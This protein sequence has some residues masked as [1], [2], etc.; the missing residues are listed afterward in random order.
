MGITDRFAFL[1][2]CIA[3]KL[4]ID[5]PENAG[6]VS[7]NVTFSHLMKKV[8]EDDLYGEPAQDEMAY[9]LGTIYPMP[10]GLKDHVRWFLGDSAFIRQIAGERHMYE[11]LKAHAGHIGSGDIPFLFIDAL[12]CR[13]GC[14]CGTAT[15][16][17]ISCT[18]DALFN[19]LNIRENVKQDSGSSTVSRA[20]TPAERLDVLN[21]QFAELELSDY[22]RGYHDLS[23]GC[24]VKVPDINEL[25]H[26]FQSMGKDTHESR[27][28]NCTSCGYNTCI[29]MATAIFNGFNHRENCVHYLKSTVETE[30]QNL[31]YK[32]QHDELL[33]IFNRY[34]AMEF[35]L[36]AGNEWKC[37]S[38]MMIDIDGFKNINATYGHEFADEV[39][40]NAANRLKVA[41]LENRWIL[42]R[43]SG[44]R[45]LLLLDDMLT[46][47]HP[48]LRLIRSLFDDPIRIGSI[49]IRISVCIGVANDNGLMNAEENINSAEEAMLAAKS[50]G[51]NKVFFYSRE[52]MEK[53]AEEK[54]ICRKLL[55]AMDNDGF[56]MVYQPKV[57]VQSLAVTGFEA[58]NRMQ[59]EWLYPGQFIPVAEKKGWIWR[60]GRITTELVVRQLAEWRDEGHRLSPVSINYSGNQLSDGGYVDFLVELLKKYDIDPKYVEIEITESVFLDKTVQAK[61]LF[62]RFRDLGIRMLMDDFGTGYSSLGYLTYIPADVIKLDKSLVDNY[63]VEGKADFIDDVI[64]LVHDI[65]KELTVEGVEEN[66][67]YMRLKDFGAD[68]IQG[69]CFS[70]PLPADKA[71]RFVPEIKQ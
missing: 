43:Y 68:T 52:L 24:S 7:Y 11:Y 61:E 9:S 64:R 21:R 44:D 39:L 15:E 56:Y 67:Q 1:S 30:Q 69:Y 23:A 37:S 5:D 4:E 29:E 22:L 41:A 32:A 46:A 47:E 26:I 51:K 53:A 60:I 49:D 25:E 31:I 50:M 12:N 3:K 27:R 62:N 63:L 28:I 40:K 2:P 14:L 18:D 13:N 16:P 20:L 57:D 71:I 36:K 6:L 70:K 35:L 17:E 48:K 66:W 34:Y 19:M 65:N 10:G 45:F 58:L 38:Y 8:R 59:N 55:N 54:M 42:S 33:D